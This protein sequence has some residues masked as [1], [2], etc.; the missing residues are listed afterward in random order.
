MIAPV[1]SLVGRDFIDVADL[2]RTDLRRILDLAHEIKAGR[3]TER[4]LA[5]RHVAMLFQRPSHRTRVSFE[6]GIARLGGST[7]T[8][9]G[10]DVQ[11]GFRE[12]V[13]DAAR[14]LDQYVD[15]VVARL[16]AHEDLLQLARSS[17]K[18]V[19]NALTDRSH[20]CQVLADLMT[21]EEVGGDLARQHVVFIGDGNN[22][23]NSLIEASAVAGFAL[24]VIT[25]PG[26]DPQPG[27]VD[28]ARSIESGNFRVTLTN[29][30]SFDEATVIYTDV[31]AS[32]GQEDERAVRQKVFGAYRVDQALMEAAPRAIFMHCLPAHRGE[33]VTDEVIDG[34]RSVVF[35]QAGNR[36]YAQMALMAGLFA[37]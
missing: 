3:W 34:P 26:Y 35:Q 24:T 31:W 37:T 36:L 9:T 28:R 6:V 18:P 7:T 27:V 17:E 23:A 19:I 25:P 14:V 5:G 22:I 16:R 8:L 15:G 32:M 10:Q 33:E 11:L 20:P 13:A 4:P 30:I 1:I 2:K 29:N 12:S 21:M